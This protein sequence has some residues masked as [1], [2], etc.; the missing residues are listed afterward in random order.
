MTWIMIRTE[1]LDDLAILPDS[2]RILTVD[3]IEE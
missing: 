2:L 3:P 1:I